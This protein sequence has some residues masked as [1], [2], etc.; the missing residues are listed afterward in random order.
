MYYGMGW[1]DLGRCRGLDPAVFH[2]DEED[3]FAVE[4][5]KAICETCP[6]RNQCLEHAIARREK[7]G[8]WGGTTW[9]ERRRIIR[10]RRTQRAA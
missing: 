3:D 1:R 2:P 5:A 6:V 9:R 10:R 8:I 7:L 4:H